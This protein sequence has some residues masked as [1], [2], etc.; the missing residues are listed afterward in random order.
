MIENQ[1]FTHRR[2]A[3]LSELMAKVRN[4][5]KLGFLFELGRKE[6]LVET[7]RNRGHIDFGTHRNRGNIGF[8]I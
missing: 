5:M 7:H 6:F 1:S 2:Y 8:L 4:F 3:Y